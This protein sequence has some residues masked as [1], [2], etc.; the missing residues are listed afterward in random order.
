MDDPLT[1]SACRRPPL[2]MNGQSI[3]ANPMSNAVNHV[4]RMT[5]R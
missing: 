1:V 5:I 4:A 3:S 2:R